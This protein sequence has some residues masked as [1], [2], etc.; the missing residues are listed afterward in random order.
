[1]SS[2]PAS[3]ASITEE[4]SSRT[5]SDVVKDFNTEELIDYLERKDL[6]LD[7]DDIKILQEKLERYGMK[8][9]PSTVLV[10]F[11]ES[12]SQK[13][14]NY[15]SLKTLDDL[16]KMLRRNKVNG[17]D[18]TS[19]KQFTPAKKLTSQDIFIVLQKDI[20][21]KPRNIKIGYAQNLAQLESAF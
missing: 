13:L 14:R 16:K 19:I 2:L 21:G 9:G 5:M 3:P 15:S 10:E 8:G 20:S 12:L 6:K 1:M 17:E 4:I 7:E 11:I 18:I